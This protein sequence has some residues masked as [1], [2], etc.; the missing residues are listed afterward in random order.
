MAR[1][2]TKITD[3]FEAISADGRHHQVVEF[4][5][6]NVSRSQSCQE[7]TIAGQKAYRL[8]P[9]ALDLYLRASQLA[10]SY[11]LEA[12]DK[13]ISHYEQA[14]R[15]D[16]GF[17]LAY[18]RLAGMLE[19]RWQVAEMHPQDPMLERIPVLIDK[20]LRLDPM[21][22]K[23]YGVLATH[24]MRTFDFKGAERALQRAEGLSPS[25]I[26]VLI[27]LS[28]YY[29]FVGWPPE[30]GVEYARRALRVDPLNPFAAT[31]VGIALWHAHEYESALR[32]T[33]KVIEVE[34]EY[35]VVHWL[36]AAVLRDLGRQGEAM[37][38]AQRA[39]ALNDYG[40]TRVDVAIGHAQLGEPDKAR[41][42]LRWLEDPTRGK[43]AH[44]TWRAWI[45]V[46]LGDYDDALSALE[47]AYAERDW[48]LIDT[49]H[50]KH[51]LPLYR[52]PRFERLVKQLGQERRIAH[53][54]HVYANVVEDSTN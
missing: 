54:A 40:D 43:Y 51:M 14:I 36:R 10:Q 6:F 41:A 18:A 53:A 9:Q 17:A 3:R 32:E 48:L 22:G 12:T 42:I 37:D 27:G 7:E 25:D 21:L 11:Q 28:Q 46:A 2:V 4:T 52:T 29:A 20:A 38:S 30:R 39:M 33:D 1:K 13:A 47:Q 23:A 45:L 16:P 49:L 8:N 19:V 24:L 50:V 34:P 5:T 26:D 35:W 44:P 31:N 15:L